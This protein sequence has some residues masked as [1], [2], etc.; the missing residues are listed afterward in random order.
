MATYT[1]DQAT[2]GKDT[3]EKSC[4]SCHG[5]TLSGSE[6]ATALKGL[7]F[8]NS[9]GGRSAE[10]LFTYIHTKMPPA[11]PGQLEPEATAQVIAYLLEQNG[12][13]PGTTELPTD[14]AALAAMQIPRGATVRSAPMM[15]L[16]PLDPP[17]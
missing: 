11:N 12:V 16:S 1:A 2:K 3:Y 17:M 8:T 6:F 5:N 13:Q 14:T 15:P 4:A 7:T 9:W 10:A